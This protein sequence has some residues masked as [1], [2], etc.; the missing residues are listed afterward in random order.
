MA[1]IPFDKTFIE[2][3]QSIVDANGKIAPTT[4][5]SCW[6]CTYPFKGTP[7]TVPVSYNKSKQTFEVVGVFCSWGCAKTWMSTRVE[8][9]TPIKRMWLYEMARRHYG[10]N[11]NVIYPAPDPWVLKRFGGSMTIEE[12][13][14]LSKNDYCETI[15]PPLL[16]ACM[17]FVHG[18]TSDVTRSL[19][20]TRNDKEKENDGKNKSNSNK[21]GIYHSFLEENREEMKTNK[22][23][24]ISPKKKK[25]TN[26]KDKKMDAPP[27]RRT[28]SSLQTFMKRT[29]E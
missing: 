20:A 6:H 27:K 7:K 25:T 21:K 13:R 14:E 29:A 28:R 9:N 4:N 12:F 18:E 15:R 2:Y 5:I 26:K 8:Y 1:C 10:Y 19:A 24:E 11:N 22:A 3:K 23:V 16:P 17:A